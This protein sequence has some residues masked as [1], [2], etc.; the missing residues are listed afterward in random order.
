LRRPGST[1]RAWLALQPESDAV[2]GAVR[3]ARFLASLCVLGVSS[4]GLP[5]RINASGD[6][7]KRALRC[8]SDYRMPIPN[9]GESGT[10]AR[11]AG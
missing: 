9:K 1:G 10:R 6:V 5:F 11:R 4:R 7:A 8:R 2:S 3:P